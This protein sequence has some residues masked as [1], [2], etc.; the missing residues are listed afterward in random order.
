MAY[1]ATMAFHHPVV[2]GTVGRQK[3]IR[4]ILHLEQMVPLRKQ[5][6]LSP[7]HLQLMVFIGASS[8]EKPVTA[9]P[10]LETWFARF[11]VILRSAQV[12]WFQAG[13]SSTS[14][15]VCPSPSA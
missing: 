11:R 8:L 4:P 10:K 13:A 14:S 3:V 1:V 6:L 2:F 15:Y 12:F 7:A 5:K 9:A